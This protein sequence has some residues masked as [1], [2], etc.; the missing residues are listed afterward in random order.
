LAP[1]DK[2]VGD[3]RQITANY[4]SA[5]IILK[6]EVGC[7]HLAAEMEDFVNSKFA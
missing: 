5:V 7:D 4:K 3:M 6:P 1:L 2:A